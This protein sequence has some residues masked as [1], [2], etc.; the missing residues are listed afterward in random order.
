MKERL[1]GSDLPSFERIAGVVVE[2]WVATENASDM[3]Y[4]LRQTQKPR[5]SCSWLKTHSHRPA[6]RRPIHHRP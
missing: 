5:F 6:F 1:T 2:L 3:R 4:T